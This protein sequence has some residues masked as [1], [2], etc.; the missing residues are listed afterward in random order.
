[1]SRFTTGP[2]QSD[3]ELDAY[4]AIVRQV[5][6]TTNDDHRRQWLERCGHENIRVVRDGT[7]VVGG[8]ILIPMGQWFGGRSVRMNGVAAVAV[9]PEHR[10][11]GAA[12]AM[13][14]AV[15]AEM[16]REGFPLSALYPATQPL[17]RAAGY[18]R[19]GAEYRVAV[20]S[21]DFEVIERSLNLRPAT[22]ADEPA[23]EEVYRRRAR[24]SNGNLDR[25]T[26]LWERIRR[27]IGITSYGFVVEGVQGIEGYLYSVTREVNPPRFDASVAPFALWLS[28]LVATTPAAARR[29][30]T[31]LAD[32]RSMTGDV[33]WRGSPADPLL[34][35]MR[36]QKFGSV[37]L[38][39]TW[40]LRI[41]DVAAALTG[42]GYAPGVAAEV[43]LDVRDEMFA[44]NAGRL[45]LR[46]SDGRA[47]VERGGGG[48]VAVDVR[49]LAALYTG[50][51]SAA[52]LRAGGL[53][54]ADEAALASACGV[55][56]SA[57]PWMSDHF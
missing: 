24:L 4:G 32:H 29:L 7:A 40:M 23:I 12:T 42:R 37:Q 57:H 51:L 39:N 36:E 47:E 52:E 38:W 16:R 30:V 8:L 2:V 9:L 15:V 26:Y 3:T 33:A 46:V 17:Y 34:A 21:P 56:A 19:A 11:R 25:G 1:M 14:R 31:F 55:F 41:V 22:A 48:G 27:P 43:H 44:E 49:G 18:E 6:N 10:S 28:D 45:V 5:Y 50:F 20:P 54:E 13:M 35:V 53:V